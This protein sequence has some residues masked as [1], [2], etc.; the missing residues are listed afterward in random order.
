ML[1]LQEEEWPQLIGIPIMVFRYPNP[2]DLHRRLDLMQELG[3]SPVSMS[4]I[5]PDNPTG[6]VPTEAELLGLLQVARERGM[7]VFGDL[8]Y[9]HLTGSGGKTMDQIL[10]E[11]PEFLD[12]TVLTAS[13]SKEFRG[14]GARLGWIASKSPQ[15]VNYFTQLAAARGSVNT[16]SQRMFAQAI[17]QDLEVVHND[18]EANIVPRARAVIDTLNDLTGGGVRVVEPEGGIYCWVDL[19]GLGVEDAAQF[20]G[21]WRRNLE[22]KERMVNYI[23]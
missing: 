14:C 6:V 18:Y 10:R 13:V 20:T 1:K 15:F 8:A 9:N 4:I 19:K 21:L 23:Q 2:A 16:I 11:H 12:N 22:K 3:E 7:W 5:A 17:G